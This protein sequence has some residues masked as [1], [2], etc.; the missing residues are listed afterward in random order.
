MKLINLVTG[1]FVER[2]DTSLPQVTASNGLT[3]STPVQIQSRDQAQLASC[4]RDLT[5][6]GQVQKTFSLSSSASKAFNKTLNASYGLASK[7]G[8]KE[9]AIA[10]VFN[11]LGIENFQQF[12]SKLSALI[13]QI[14]PLFKAAAQNSKGLSADI[15]KLRDQWNLYKNTYVNI[16]Q[17]R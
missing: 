1:N 12:A 4:L 6:L 16:V 3:L 7:M 2:P 17:R 10:S 5:Y 15:N 14:E 8:V 11:P 9:F 13:N